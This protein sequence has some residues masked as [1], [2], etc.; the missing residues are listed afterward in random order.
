MKGSYMRGPCDCGAEDCIR[1]YP[2]NFR[3]GKYIGDGV[4]E[5]EEEDG[6][7]LAYIPE[8][9]DEDDDGSYYDYCYPNQ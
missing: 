8:N 9:E 7:G 2:Q 4:E 5:E 3:N 6:D 1:C